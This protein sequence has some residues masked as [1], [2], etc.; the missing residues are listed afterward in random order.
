MQQEVGG[1]LLLCLMLLRWAL[2]HWLWFVCF[3]DWGGDSGI[4][5]QEDTHTHSACGTRAHTGA[6]G[7]SLTWRV[8]L[9]RRQG[10]KLTLV[11]I[12]T[13]AGNGPQRH[14]WVDAVKLHRTLLYLNLTDLTW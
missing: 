1:F 3:L 14:T 4:Q 2:R 11:G 9:S 10:P 12:T 7:I 5:A 6:P 13:S 8:I